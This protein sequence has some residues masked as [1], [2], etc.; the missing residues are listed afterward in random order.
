MN[1]YQNNMHRK[2]QHALRNLSK[3]TWTNRAESIHAVWT[4]CEVIM[5]SFSTIQNSGDF[6]T[7][8]KV[9]ARRLCEAIKPLATVLQPLKNPNFQDV[10]ELVSLFPSNMPVDSKQRSFCFACRI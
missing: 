9:T 2:R 1:V 3:T 4:S 6:D 10:Q 5:N 7:S 8:I